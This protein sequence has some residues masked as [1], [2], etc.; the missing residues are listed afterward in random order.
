M[1]EMAE[2]LAMPD[3]ARLVEAWNKAFGGLRQ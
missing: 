2:I 3:V 1:I